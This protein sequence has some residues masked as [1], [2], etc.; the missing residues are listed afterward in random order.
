MDEKGQEK[1]IEKIEKEL[2]QTKASEKPCS[3]KKATNGHKR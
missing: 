2:S 3:S 1:M